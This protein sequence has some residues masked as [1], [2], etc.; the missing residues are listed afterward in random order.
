MLSLIIKE[1]QIRT[2]MR[3]HFLPIELVKLRTFNNILCQHGV[4]GNRN[5]P[6]MGKSSH[7]LLGGQFDNID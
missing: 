4:W 5:S 6:V 2:T 3:Y 7:I 1:M